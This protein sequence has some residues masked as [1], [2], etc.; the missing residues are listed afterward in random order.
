M[1]VYVRTLYCTLYNVI[2]RVLTRFIT[3]QFDVI[4]KII[5]VCVHCDLN[6]LQY[7]FCR[8]CKSAYHEGPCQ[9]VQ[10]TAAQAP[11][12][13]NGQAQPNPA[14]V[15]RAGWIEANERFIHDNTKPC[16]RC[17]APIEKSGQSTYTCTM[18]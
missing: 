10:Q 1:I 8:N 6:V 13:Q 12:Q 17:K 11:S 18:S 2:F 3:T 5:N 16:P 9:R 15:Q 14:N 4:Y 7:V